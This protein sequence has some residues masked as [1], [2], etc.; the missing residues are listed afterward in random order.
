MQTWIFFIHLLKT[1][2]KASI[3][4]KEVFLIESGLMIANNLIFYFIW[5]IFFGQFNDI[6]GWNLND[7]KI[8]LTVGLGGYGLMQTLFGGTK[9]LSRMIIDGD[10]D[11]FMIQPKNLLLHV[12]SSKS[13]A[14]GWGH[15][16]TSLF[17]MQFLNWSMIPLL[18]VCIICSCLIFTSCNIIAHSLPFWMGSIE[19]LSKKYCDALFLFAHYPTNI[20]S[21]LLHLIMFTLIPAGLISY[22]PVELMRHFSWLQFFILIVSTATI[23]YAAFLIFYSGLKKYESGNKFGVRL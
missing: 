10:L 3:S 23:V 18:L 2:L 6:A 12:I 16:M 22:L 14:K 20:Y 8:V 19:S 15:L 17:L 4:K 13:H 1:A 21:G 9:N 5:W 11:S 7:M